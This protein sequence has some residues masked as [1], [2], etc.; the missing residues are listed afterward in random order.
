M[1]TKFFLT[2]T[3]TAKWFFSIVLM[4]GLFWTSNANAQLAPAGDPSRI[5][6]SSNSIT[7]AQFLALD[8]N[9]Q[10]H[11]LSAP[12]FEISDLRNAT[13]EDFLHATTDQVFITSEDFYG[14]IIEKQLDILHKPEVYKIYKPN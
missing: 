13:A 9:M 14:A 1:E 10:L 4:L 7:R 12:P 8:D 11:F 5:P 2:H 6:P 3:R